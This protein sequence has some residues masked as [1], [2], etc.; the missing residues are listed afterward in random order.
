MVKK[1][2][3][4]TIDLPDD[5][6][7]DLFDEGNIELILTDAIVEE[8]EELNVCKGSINIEFAEISNLF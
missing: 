5:F 4:I 3:T 7:S 6:D 1:E 2:I 8:L